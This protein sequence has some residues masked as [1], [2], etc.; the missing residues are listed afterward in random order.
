MYLK[1]KAAFIGAS[2]LCATLICIY[3]TGMKPE[4]V[5]A[6]DTEPVVETQLVPEETK[7]CTPTPIPTPTPKPAPYLVEQLIV[8]FSEEDFLEK[9]SKIFVRNAYGTG[10]YLHYE[11][12]DFTVSDS[13]T[14]YYL[15]EDGLTKLTFT[16]VVSLP[17]ELEEELNTPEARYERAL[18]AGEINGP[19]D[20]HL[21]T[22]N[23]VFNGPSGRETFYN[24]KMGL[25]VEYMRD[26]GYSEEDYPYWVR[27]DGAKMLG[28]YV[29]VAANWKIRPKGTI[30]ETSLGTAIVCDT[31]TF[32]NDY[33]EGVD[34]AV[35]WRV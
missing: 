20:S 34:I 4:T 28:N 13:Y 3:I 6:A 24:L 30:I 21:N 14:A 1:S 19:S 18:A 15:S 25:V 8:V 17:A 35:D 31:G 5:T 32:V 16:V 29:M 9:T 26:L 12:V 10:Y 27:D 33:P 7:I 23:G 22:Y 2:I 11:D